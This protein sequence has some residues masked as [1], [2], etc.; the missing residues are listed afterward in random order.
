MSRVAVLQEEMTFSFCCLNELP[1]LC[2]LNLKKLFSFAL[3]HCLHHCGCDLAG[4]GLGTSMDKKSLFPSN[5]SL[6]GPLHQNLTHGGFCALGDA[7]MSFQF[8]HLVTWPQL[9][10]APGLRVGC[11]LPPLSHCRGAGHQHDNRGKWCGQSQVCLA[12]LVRSA[13]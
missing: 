6:K 1:G 2:M 13:S 12:S 8:Q 10:S 3:P 7:W 5:L 11:W 9:C 4:R